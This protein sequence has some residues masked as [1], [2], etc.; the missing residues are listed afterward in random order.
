MS[1]TTAMCS[2]CRREQTAWRPSA[3]DRFSWFPPGV[4]GKC[5]GGE[6]CYRTGYERVSAALIDCSRAWSAAAQAA[7]SAIARAD[8]AERERDI[9]SALAAAGGYAHA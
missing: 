8:K 7:G 9:L 4:E 6:D 3:D 5:Y 1:E 2:V